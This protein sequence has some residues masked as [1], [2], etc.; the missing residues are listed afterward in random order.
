ME[1]YFFFVGLQHQ[2]LCAGLCGFVVKALP[3][4]AEV[5]GLNLVCPHTG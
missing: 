3:L 2:A 1:Q 4:N 5:T